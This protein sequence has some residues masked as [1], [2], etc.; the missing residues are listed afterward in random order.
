MN[1]KCQEAE[2][3][4]APEVRADWKKPEVTRFSAGLAETGDVTRG[5][6]PGFS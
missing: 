4:Q 3:D 6:G 1:D 2:Q 5:D